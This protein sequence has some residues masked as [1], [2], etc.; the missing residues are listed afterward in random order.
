MAISKPTFGA[1]G[2]NTATDAVIDFVN[3]TPAITVNGSTATTLDIDTTAVTAADVGADPAGTAASLLHYTAADAGWMG[4]AFDPALISGSSI[5]TAG[6]LYLTRVKVG[7]AG[8]AASVSM[9]VSTAGATLSNC[10]LGLF[11][12]NGTRVGVTTDQSTALQSGGL[13]TVTMSATAA[14]V[15]G[16]HYVGI[17]TNGT[18]PPTMT[19]AGNSSIVNAGVVAPS[20]RWATSGTGQTAMPSTVDLTTAAAS[21]LSLWAAIKS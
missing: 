1:P 13:K 7:V 4:W 14:L 19:R 9:H 17:L 2:W 5:L 6:V 21:S 16:P 8:T 20:L 3:A 18:T 12:S 15:A 11:D 10:F